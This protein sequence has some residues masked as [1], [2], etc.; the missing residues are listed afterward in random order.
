MPRPQSKAVPAVRLKPWGYVDDDGRPHLG[1][2][3]AEP[4]ALSWVEG[5]RPC[6]K[7][8]TMTNWTTARGRPVHPCCDPRAVHDRLSVEAEF[9]LED[10]LLTLLPVRLIVDDYATPGRRPR[11]VAYL[12]APCELCGHAERTLDYLICQRYR[13]PYRS[14]RCQAHAMT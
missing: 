13:A 14:I 11:V 12:G 10:E 8:R 6:S 9:D 5:A 3:L 7:C 2:E 4:E 1:R